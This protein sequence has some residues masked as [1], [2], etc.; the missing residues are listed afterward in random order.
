[1]TPSEIQEY[2]NARQSVI[3]VYKTQ[4]QASHHYFAA[5]AHKLIEPED[6]PINYFPQIL[7]ITRDNPAARQPTI[8]RFISGNTRPG[9]VRGMKAVIEFR[10][11]LPIGPYYSLWQDQRAL[12]ERYRM[13]CRICTAPATQCRGEYGDVP[14]C[15]NPQ[16]VDIVDREDY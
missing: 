4:A 5:T 1:M 3:F 2:F 8:L 11:G 9:E 7:S 16:C 12:N 13:K 14:T 6:R 10:E 15:G